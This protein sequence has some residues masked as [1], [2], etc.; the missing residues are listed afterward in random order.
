MT[1][2]GGSSRL[3]PR[4]SEQ[5]LPRRRLDGR[6]HRA[7]HEGEYEINDGLVAGLIRDQMPQWASLALRRFDSTGT[8]NI[9]Y[10][11]GADKLVRLPRHPDFSHGPLTESEWLPVLGPELPLAIPEHLALGQ[12]GDDYPSHWSVLSWI[13][14]ENATRDTLAD[15][16]DTAQGLAAFIAKLRD[17]PTEGA[18]QTSYRGHGLSTVDSVLRQRIGRLPASFDRT[19]ILE[20]WQWCVSAP[21]WDGPPT[22][23]HGDLYSDNLLARDGELFA[24]IDWEG[25]SAGDPAI[26]LIAAWWLFDQSSRETFRAAV[27]PDQPQWMRGMGWALFM[28][29]S[30]FPYYRETN[31]GFAELAGRAVDE[32]LQDW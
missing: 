21:G 2:K 10:R 4:V 26:D 9:A 18:P 11:L 30:A 14:G 25:C 16:H 19:A 12:P 20:A 8:V 15:L 7:L 1:A 29:V 5:T 31:P 22:W 28:G 13:E 27:D 23:F 17:L 6:E 32:I 24:A 3:V